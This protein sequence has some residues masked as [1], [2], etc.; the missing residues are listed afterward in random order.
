MSFTFG[1]TDAKL[2]KNSV[3][4]LNVEIATMENVGITISKKSETKKAQKELDKTVQSCNEYFKRFI[5]PTENCPLCG[6]TIGGIFG[7]FEW[8]IAHGEGGCSN[9]GYPARAYH[10]IEGM[11]SI[12]NLILFYHPNELELK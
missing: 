4:K 12:K 3:G 7:T 9:C 11:G 10:N 6:A 1:K 5:K 8:G 2:T